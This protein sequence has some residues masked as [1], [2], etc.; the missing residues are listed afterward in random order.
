MNNLHSPNKPILS[1]CLI[2]KNEKENLPRCLTSAKPYVD[3][4]IV[5]DTGS[6]DGTP[7]IALQY[8]AKISYFEWCDDFAAAR[9][10]AISQASGDW[11]L[12]LDADEELV[13]KESNFLDKI[14]SQPE[15]I[16]YS[17]A[18]TE[19]NDQ[20]PATPSLR[21]SLFRNI[22]KHRYIGRFHECLKNHNQALG[23]KHNSHLKSLNI[24]HHGFNKKQV[25]QKI[26]SRSIPLLERIKQEDGLSLR[27]LSSLA[28]MYADN[29][30]L[31]KA[32]ECDR[33]VFERLLPYLKNGNPPD[34]F[35]FIPDI[36]FVLGGKSLQEKDYE[37]AIL[38]CQ[39]G[40]EWCPSH[41]PLN[42]LIGVTIKQL[43]FP[44]GAI[45]YFKN[46]LHFG[47]EGN[48]YKEEP[49]ELSYMTI[50]PAYDL[51]SIYLELGEFHEA[52]AAFELVLSF[53]PHF[54][55]AQNQVDK[56][57]EYLTS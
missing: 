46:C 38:I 54:I 48:Y 5:V 40:F 9:N 12:M 55:P 32:Q 42:Y 4:I 20:A 15:I 13:V 29:Q 37:T 50:Y 21:V 39:R 3:E 2:V 27:L 28:G 49:F 8:G 16:A 43:G 52:L 25:Q 10:Y 17:L 19:V 35:T 56:I 47:Q 30:Q 26:I 41:P 51:G 36:L 14:T 6:V 53:D 33:E 22:S 11:I 18:Y 34:E 24:I 7:E 44:L 45:G 31:E 57:K 23:S 1:L